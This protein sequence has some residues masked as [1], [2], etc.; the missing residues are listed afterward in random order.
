MDIL[1]RGTR[2][3]VAA[4]LRRLAIM[5]ALAAI[6][7]SPAP[8]QSSVPPLPALPVTFTFSNCDSGVTYQATITD[9]LRDASGNVDPLA[10]RKVVQPTTT[11]YSYLFWG[12]FS[13]TV[14]GT[15]QTAIGAS[16]PDGSVGRP[17]GAL[18]IMYQNL[19]IEGLP[20][21][22]SF[23]LQS[24]N[25]SG[26]GLGTGAATSRLAWTASLYGPGN[27]MPNGV[28]SPLPPISAWTPANTFIQGDGQLLG[29]PI[30]QYGGCGASGAVEFA[31]LLGIA[32]AIP[33]CVACGEPINVA[34]RQRLREFHRLPDL[35]AE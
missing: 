1:I 19:G 6:A 27:S 10:A 33:G 22:T 15:T 4:C 29:R 18:T 26:L 21:N 3:S 31:K 16:G 34:N 12:S 13:M 8:G 35:R 11:T 30:T 14:R 5:I 24:S 7:L 28:L 23:L 9:W 20:A 2:G 25:A 17:L 32:C